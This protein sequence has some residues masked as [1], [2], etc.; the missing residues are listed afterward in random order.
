MQANKVEVLLILGGNPTYSAPADIQ[1]ENHL[2]TVP[3][4]V[5]LGMYDDET[6]ELCQW[7]IPDTHYLEAWS[8]LRAYDGTASVVQP[9]IAPLYDSH[10][11]HELLAALTDD[12]RTGYDIVRDYWK[13]TL[14]AGD[15]ERAWSK[16]L[17]DGLFAGTA[18]PA[19][20]F[21]LAATFAATLPA[22]KASA[23]DSIEVNFA[24]DQTVWDGRYANNGWLQGTA[25]NPVESDVG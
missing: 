12:D 24:P 5:H 17:N 2:K 9:L 7:H 21:P 15:F 20:T 18:L 23:A 10:S 25:E 14:A 11:A 6:S 8:D 13:R 16:G 22:A 3:L 4:R 1:F 19:K